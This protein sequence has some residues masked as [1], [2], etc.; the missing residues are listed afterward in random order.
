MGKSTKKRYLTESYKQYMRKYYQE[1][2]DTILA[3][4][5]RA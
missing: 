5:K 4:A 3:N 2:K 1:H